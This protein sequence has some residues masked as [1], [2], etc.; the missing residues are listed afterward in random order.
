[1]EAPTDSTIYKFTMTASDHSKASLSTPQLTQWP[2]AVPN[3]EDWLT[4]NV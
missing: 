2:A 3:I 4:P 1:M